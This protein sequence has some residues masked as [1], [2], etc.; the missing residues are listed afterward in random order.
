MTNP[1]TA[2]LSVAIDKQYIDLKLTFSALVAVEHA[3]DEGIFALTE[4]LAAGG[5][6]LR[7][8]A[9]VLG[10]A[11]VASGFERRSVDAVG[12]TILK[13]GIAVHAETTVRLLEL[14]LGGRATG[15]PSPSAATA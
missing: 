3:L 13:D 10:E 9:V 8:I 5:M 12:E 2:T 7:D 14:A 15:K 6:R 4:R 1:H 11:L